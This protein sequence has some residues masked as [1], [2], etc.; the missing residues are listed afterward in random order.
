LY[1]GITIET[2][3]SLFDLIEFNNIFP[4][5]DLDAINIVEVT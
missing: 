4:L 2:N 1:V 3:G 5:G